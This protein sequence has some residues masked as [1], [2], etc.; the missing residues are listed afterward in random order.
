MEVGSAPIKL[1]SD[2]NQKLIKLFP[3]KLSISS[4]SSTTL[5]MNFLFIQD[6]NV[7]SVIFSIIL[8]HL[9]YT[10]VY[11]LLNWITYSERNFVIILIYINK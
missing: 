2:P 11:Y 6:Y 10:K 8:F 9:I 4:L 7:M 5:K 3:F 1:R